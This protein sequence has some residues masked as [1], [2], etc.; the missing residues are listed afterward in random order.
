[1]RKLILLFIFLSSFILIS[2]QSKGFG[3][4]IIVGEPTGISGKYWVSSINSI[5][6]AAAWSFKGDGAI[7]LQADYVFHEYNLIK[8]NKGKLPVYFGIGGRVFL[9]DEIIIGARVPIGISYMFANA[10]VDIFL[11]VVPVLNLVPA[12]DFSVDGGIGFRYFF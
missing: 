6:M 11:E 2:A 5:N 12:T 8:V 4:G 9:S 3:A 7:L 1:M 10:P